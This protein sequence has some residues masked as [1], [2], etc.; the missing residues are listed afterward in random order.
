[1]SACLQLDHVYVNTDWG[2]P[3]FTDLSFALESGGAALVVGGS[4]S[5]KSVL[6]EMLI[7]ARKPTSGSIEVLGTKVTQASRMRLRKLRAQ[8]GGVGGAWALVDAWSVA[9]NVVLPLVI[10]GERPKQVRERVIKALGDFQL[11]NIADSKV[12]RLT[13]SQRFLTQFARASI[14]H[15]PLLLV[16]EPMVGLDRGLLSL[17]EEK[18]L[19][20]SVSGRTILLTSSQPLP[21]SI[22]SMQRY[23]F[24]HGQLFPDRE[25]RLPER[26]TPDGEPKS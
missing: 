13:A 25:P 10:Q 18:L 24:A 1:M 22:P 8:I 2:E 16:D 20:A 19:A 26:S 21:I 4:G 14:A 15:Q 12:S 5:G 17:V 11:G 3:L 7:G 6:L 9:E 23:H